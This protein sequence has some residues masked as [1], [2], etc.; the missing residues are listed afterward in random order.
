M[1]LHNYAY[2]PAVRI[3][4]YN[5]G[6]I[7]ELKDDVKDLII[8]RLIVRDKEEGLDSFLCKW[9]Q[10][11][12]VMLEISKYDSD[13]ND[14]LNKKLNNH[15]NY[16]SDQYDFFSSKKPHQIIPIINEESTKHLRDV[17]QLSRRLINNFDKLAIKLNMKAHSFEDSFELLKTIL[18]AF[19]DTEISKV[20]IIVDLGK[21]E[22]L[23]D[24]PQQKL[25]EAL[26]FIQQYEFHLVVFSSTSYPATRPVSGSTATAPCLDPYWQYPHINQLKQLNTQAV[27][28]DYSATDPSTEVYNF[29]FVVHPIPYATY[30]LKDSLEWYLLR[31]GSGGE[32]EK[33]RDIAKNIQAHS[34]YHG[35]NFCYANRMTADISSGTRNKAGNQAFWNKLKINEHISAIVDTHSKGLLDVT[36]RYTD[37]DTEDDDF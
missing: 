18:S 6:A 32:Y 7:T 34:G 19:S 16:F 12:P 15:S 29:D 10:E 3:S 9:G 8:P 2:V 31:D 23:D 37:N 30:L 5:L 25:G 22:T 33:F 20:I 13:L 17:M 14:A 35:D 24:I 36:Q 26:S 4:T 27:Y 21:I 11:R 28:G 1:D